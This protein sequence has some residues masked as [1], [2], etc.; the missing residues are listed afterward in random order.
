MSET[1]AFVGAA[2]GVGTTALTLACGT[3]LA[4]E[5]NDTAILDAAY[6]TQGLSD[7]ITGRID[8]DMTT[9]CLEDVPLEE[10]LLDLP[11][12]GAGR[13]TACPAH[14][15]FGRLA[16]AK[17]ADAAQRFERRIDE[18]TRHFEYVLIDVPPLATNPGVAAA[19]AAET[20]VVVADDDRADSTVPRTEDR[21]ADIGADR[22]LTVVTR[23]SAHPDADVA[24][25]PFEGETPAS[26][27]GSDAYD[28]LIDVI[29]AT[30]DVAIERAD[31][32]GFLEALP[33]K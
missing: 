12:D 29:T 7:H 25:S 22:S 13:L 23:T 3:L 14:A 5:G 9:L 26:D 20:V 31:S 21:L 30:T 2:G 33:L 15:P 10:G 17:T 6:G 28:D 4:G 19:T 18:A 24:L 32:G 27:P 16:R 11:I 8:P 1:V